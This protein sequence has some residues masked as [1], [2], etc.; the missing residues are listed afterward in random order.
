[1]V[2]H[3]IVI[4]YLGKASRIPNIDPDKYSYIDLLNDAS[5]IALNAMPGNLNLLLHM[6]CLI[7]KTETHLE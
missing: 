3:D 1:M 6:R 7:P 4:H 2:A 5:E